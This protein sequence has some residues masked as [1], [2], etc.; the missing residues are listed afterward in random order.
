MATENE[1]RI[2]ELTEQLEA[3]NAVLRNFT[4]IVLCSNR[5]NTPEFMEN[6]VSEC[7]RVCKFLG[8]PDRFEMSRGWIVRRCEQLKDA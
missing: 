3:A 5:S 1:T 7:N 4:S 8:D 6:L 2:A